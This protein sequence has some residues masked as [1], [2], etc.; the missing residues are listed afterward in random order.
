MKGDFSGAFFQA[1]VAELTMAVICNGIAL[2]GG[3]FV[4]CGTFFVFSDYMKPASTFGSVNGSSGEIRLS[5]DA[6]RVG[7]DGPTHQPIEHEAQLRLMEKLE[8]H[9]GKMSLLALRPADAAETSVAWK[10][11]M[12]NTSTPTALILSRQNITDLPGTDRYDEAL[13]QEKKVLTW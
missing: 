10:M 7:E 4:A 13:C 8:N 6:F 5:H 12:E 2:H 9:S 1:G 11:A 3:I